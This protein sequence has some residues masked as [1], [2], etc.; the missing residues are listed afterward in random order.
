MARA[1][2]A[3]CL[4]LAVAGS[5]L[6]TENPTKNST[7]VMARIELDNTVKQVNASLAKLKTNIAKELCGV[8]ETDVTIHKVMDDSTKIAGIGNTQTV[9]YASC[10]A[11]NAKL[12]GVR[13][14]CEDLWNRHQV[15][16]ETKDSTS[17]WKGGE[18]EVDDIKCRYVEN[19]NPV[20][21]SRGDETKAA[22]T[23]VNGTAADG[24]TMKPAGSAAAAALPA[25]ALALACA[26]FALLL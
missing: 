3:L 4:F 10:K 19:N 15:K 17:W 8:P 22:A 24:M 2:L 12:E 16:D 11:P 21:F 5:V 14:D 7:A 20:Y 18:L 1:A 26:A 6:A 23:T 25:T 13:D 9:V